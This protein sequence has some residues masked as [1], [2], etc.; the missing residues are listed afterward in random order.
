[1][2]GRMKTVRVLAGVEALAALIAVMTPK[3][4]LEVCEAPMHCYYSYMAEIGTA[5]VVIAAALATFASKGLEAPRMLSVATAACGAGFIMYPAWLIG[6]CGSPKMACHYGLLPVW[7]LMGGL[8]LLLS[9]II[10]F[11]AKEAQD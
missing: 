8:I 1:M 9:I 10:F 4:G 2:T 6:V 3:M 5:G 7:N 11:I